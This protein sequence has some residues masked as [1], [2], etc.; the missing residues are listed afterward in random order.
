MML[1]QRQAHL[2]YADAIKSVA[3]ETAKILLDAPRA[4]LVDICTLEIG[5]LVTVDFD[6]HNGEHVTTRTRRVL[7][8]HN[9]VCEVI[10]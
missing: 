4:E 7:V 6:A 8:R 1:K 3:F 2:Y 10:L 5:V 9:G